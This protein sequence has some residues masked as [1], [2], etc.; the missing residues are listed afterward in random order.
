M[1]GIKQIEQKY[2]KIGYYKYL[3]WREWQRIYSWSDVKYPKR[4][5]NLHFHLP[6]SPEGMK[7]N[8]GNKLLH[9]LHDKSNY[10]VH[11]RYLKQALNHI[12][13]STQSNQEAWLKPYMDMNSEFRKQAK[14]FE[15]GFFRLMDNSVLE[16]Q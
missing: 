6:L 14:D 10:V 7:I 2:F 13:E 16:K 8:K 12:K 11:I 4:R 1:K 5:H 9:N 15:K 3:W